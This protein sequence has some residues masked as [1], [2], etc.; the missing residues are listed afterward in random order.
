MLVGYVVGEMDTGYN[1]ACDYLGSPNNVIRYPLG[2]D[3]LSITLYHLALSRR[4]ILTWRN[5]PSSSWL[6]HTGTLWTVPRSCRLLHFS[7]V[8]INLPFARGL[9]ILENDLEW[10]A[11]RELCQCPLE[12]GIPPPCESGLLPTFFPSGWRVAAAVFPTVFLSLVCEQGHGA[13]VLLGEERLKGF[14]SVPV[15]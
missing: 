10:C 2:H 8:Q 3:H 6:Q 15:R 9:L 12:E 7:I 5:F 13:K 14:A 1:N 11:P 4:A